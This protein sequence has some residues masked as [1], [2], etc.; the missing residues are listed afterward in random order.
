MGPDR[1]SYPPI[2]TDLPKP[3]PEVE[4][5][6]ES[7]QNI[8]LVEAQDVTVE[9]N[10]TDSLPSLKKPGLLGSSNGESIKTGETLP[11]GEKTP[12]ELISETRNEYINSFSAWQE[13][14]QSKPSKKLSSMERGNWDSTE[15]LLSRSSEDSY[16][17][18]QETIREI[19]KLELD[20]E[21]N[22]SM[23]EWTVGETEMRMAVKQAELVEKY[24]IQE[25]AYLEEKKIETWP[26]REKGWWKTTLESYSQ[27]PKSLKFASS[28]VVGTVIAVSMPGIAVGGM[29]GL[30]G[31][32]GLRLARGIGGSFVG[33]GIN[34]LVG[35][36]LGRN[37]EKK[38]KQHK[39]KIVSS[40]SFSK[41]T[42][43]DIQKQHE[44]FLL[45]RDKL[46]T[47]NKWLS[48]IAGVVSGAGFSATSGMLENSVATNLGL[49][50]TILNE[51][52]LVDGKTIHPEPKSYFPGHS[53]EEQINSD[54]GESHPIP[55]VEL[56]YESASTPKAEVQ[57][58]SMVDGSAPKP[59]GFPSGSKV[60]PDL[61]VEIDNENLVSQIERLT[62][63]P[64]EGFW[65]PISREMEFRIK[66]DPEKYGLS[67]EDVLDEDS[68]EL[69]KA[70]AK[71][72]NR[73][74]RE[75]EIIDSSGLEK[76]INNPGEVLELTEKDEI[77]VNPKSVYVENPTEIKSPKLVAEV[78]SGSNNEP[79][80]VEPRS[81]VN[82]LD[83]SVLSR[84]VVGP[85]SL[86]EN[87]PIENA[88]PSQDWLTP[89]LQA[90]SELVQTEEALNSFNN[91]LDLELYKSLPLSGQM[92]FSNILKDDSIINYQLENYENYRQA[93]E[94]GGI[95]LPDS[96]LVENLKEKI[97]EMREIYEDTLKAKQEIISKLP[98]YDG[99]I[100]IQD[101]LKLWKSGESANWEG[102]YGDLAEEISEMN[103]TDH[104]LEKSLEEFLNDHVTQN[105]L[106]T[107]N[108]I[109]AIEIPSY[110]IA[111]I[112]EEAQR[113]V[114]SHAQ[115]NMTRAEMPDYMENLNLS[116]EAGKNMSLEE[117]NKNFINN[118]EFGSIKSDLTD[119]CRKA[120]E[121]IKSLEDAGWKVDSNL[122]DSIHD[123]I[124]KMQ[125]LDNLSDEY[126]EAW[127]EFL[128][129]AGLD[130]QS[131]R[132]SIVEAKDNLGNPVTID[133]GSVLDMSKNYTP[134]QM[135]K[136]SDFVD[137]VSKLAEDLTPEELVEVRKL[138]VDQ[139]IKQNIKL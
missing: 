67:P 118:P 33:A 34:K 81:F 80:V 86:I 68:P 28:A 64:K 113:L 2:P 85:E 114:N 138:P 90:H 76:R 53:P 124:E 30:T 71:E 132:N 88:N 128:S 29:V 95:D 20:K 87:A 1:F 70:V 49:K 109:K 41:L 98:N 13:F 18:Y 82:P 14:K 27:L 61:P 69:A 65:Q 35:G 127:K 73:I 131:Y 26:P 15:E 72:T 51:N 17:K 63:R 108:I 105:G 79:L 101:M 96:D 23:K 25:S 40:E 107:P 21:R 112:S 133:T 126:S 119:I 115:I 122:K 39:E 22:V 89:D 130:E 12:D 46:K 55:G 74:L 78:I 102:G 117:F 93:V 100:Q 48:I 106:E 19:V 121:N 43:E 120:S 139:F 62:V 60:T 44:E 45:K 4:V 5:V 91:N 37:L 110:S 116:L 75:N 135:G 111:K 42:F 134:S 125:E 58:E 92:E 10:E 36:I 11:E 129:D 38:T 94:Q 99:K 66:A 103:L 54:L 7:I 32:A 24:V 52:N 31:I 84:P 104:D 6:D 9:N 97:T 50:H 77:L 136:F 83:N 47:R 3:K 137:G 16:K 123:A 56:N 57:P 8:P 59:E